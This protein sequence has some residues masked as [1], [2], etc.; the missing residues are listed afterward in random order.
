M[1]ICICI[2]LCIYIICVFQALDLPKEHYPICD[3]LPEDVITRGILSS[4]QLEGIIHA[5]RFSLFT[6]LFVLSLY[7]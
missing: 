5:V 2:Y 1:Y 3:S 4:L 6:L 7:F